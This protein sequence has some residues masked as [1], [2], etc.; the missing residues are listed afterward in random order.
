MSYFVY[1]D[2]KLKEFPEKKDHSTKNKE[3]SELGHSH[4]SP[5]VKREENANKEMKVLEKKA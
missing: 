1:F 3:I 2:Q 5:S 4:L